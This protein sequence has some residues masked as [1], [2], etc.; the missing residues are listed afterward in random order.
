MVAIGDNN[1]ERYGSERTQRT[2]S[3]NYGERRVSSSTARR[4]SNHRTTDRNARYNEHGDSFKRSR[5]AAKKHKVSNAAK[6]SIGL[7]AALALIIA[8]E[9]STIAQP[10]P[11]SMPTN[12]HS[13]SEIAEFTDVPDT[14]LYQLN[15]IKEGEKTP[16][17]LIVPEKYE[18]YEDKIDEIITKLQD[19][20]ISAE[21]RASLSIK[22]G[23]LQEKQNLQNEV[24]QVYKNCDK[25]YIVPNASIAYEELKD[26]FNIPD[27]EIIKYNDISSGEYKGDETGCTYIDYTNSAADEGEIIEIPLS[28]INPDNN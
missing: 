3:R 7:S 20:N 22:L 19:D 16:D 18:A 5:P 14:L 21:E 9:A 26:T 27:G 17:T 12:G 2:Q 4:P 28:D 23:E 1:Y 8:H 13:I 6:L 10:K 15:D 11:A 24:A 25:A